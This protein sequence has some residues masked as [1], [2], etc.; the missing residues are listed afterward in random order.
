LND[1]SARASTT[2]PEARRMKMA[3]GGTRPAYNVQAAT[4]VESGIIVR[5]EV[6]NQGTDAGLMRP[7][8]EGIETVY[9]QRPKSSLLDG[10]FGNKEDVEWAHGKDIIVYSPLRNE[11]KDRECGKDPYSPK[12]GEGEGVKAWRARMGTEAAKEWYKKRGSTA[13]WVNAGM[14]NR[15]LYQV[16][17]RGVSKVRAVV[18]LQALVHNV[19]QTMRLCAAKGQKWT[20][21]ICAGLEKGKAKRLM[22]DKELTQED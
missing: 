8:L 5:V 22:S 13:E 2:D 21:I 14:R 19:F 6:S 10:G 12:R 7:M 1:N 20:A 18:L 15:G 4:T 16:L 3:D 17:V 11:K 9:G